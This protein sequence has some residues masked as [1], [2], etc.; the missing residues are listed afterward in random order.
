MK[1]SLRNVKLAEGFEWFLVVV[2][3]CCDTSGHQAIISS[4]NQVPADSHPSAELCTLYL[5]PTPALPHR[6]RQIQAAA[7]GFLH[8]LH[9][10]PAALTLPSPTLRYIGALPYTAFSVTMARSRTTLKWFWLFKYFE[11]IEIID[12]QSN[13][14]MHA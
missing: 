11:F 3:L 7:R 8:T 1:V 2:V 6:P 13:L 5:V 10:P 12:C 14:T 9:Q 4:T